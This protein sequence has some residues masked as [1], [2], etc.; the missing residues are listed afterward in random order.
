MK[1]VFHQA[2]MCYLRILTNRPNR[3]AEIF[4][5]AYYLLIA[6]VVQQMLRADVTTIM[7]FLPNARN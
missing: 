6:Y 7:E 3:I 1:S 2:L 5:D 4:V